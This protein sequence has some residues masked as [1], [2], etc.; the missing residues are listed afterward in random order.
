MTVMLKDWVKFASQ[1][2]LELRVDDPSF[3][4][5]TLAEYYV[6]E[7]MESIAVLKI[8]LAPV[9]VHYFCIFL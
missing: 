9:F 6:K 4:L 5:T 3:R 1:H 7:V 2:L 8:I